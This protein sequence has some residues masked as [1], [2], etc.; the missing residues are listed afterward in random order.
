MLRPVTRDEYH[1]IICQRVLGRLDVFLGETDDE[2]RL[3]SYGRVASVAVNG[4]ILIILGLCIVG[5]IQ[6]FVWLHA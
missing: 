4:S 3:V 2:G 6:K 1:R 5:A